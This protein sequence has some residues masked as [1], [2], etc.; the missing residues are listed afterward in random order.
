MTLLTKLEIS[1]IPNLS[2]IPSEIAKLKVLKE[3]ILSDNSISQIAD[4]MGTLVELKTL[5]LANN[6][7]LE[8]P[9]VEQILR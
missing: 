3:L 2:E 8:F 1:N 4:Q 7:L 5:I 9:K 6:Q